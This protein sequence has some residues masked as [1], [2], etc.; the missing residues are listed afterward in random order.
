MKVSRPQVVKKLWAYLK[1][2]D[3][4]VACTPF[5]W[6]YE[7]IPCS[8]IFPPILG[9]GEQ[10]VVHSRQ[11]HGACL[12]LRA[13]E[14]LWDVQALEGT[15][16]QPWQLVPVLEAVLFPTLET[17]PPKYALTWRGYSDHYFVLSDFDHLDFPTMSSPSKVA[18]DRCK[19]SD[20]VLSS[21]E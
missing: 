14:V 19:I 3:L 9:Q 6:N 10:A 4:Q 5:F 2:K 7:T 17:F 13:P 8:C 21:Y 18:V 20:S 16:H 15:S 11:N 12:R 1:E